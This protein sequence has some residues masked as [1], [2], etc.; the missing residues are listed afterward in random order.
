MVRKLRNQY[1]AGLVECRT[2]NA[3]VLGSFG[4]A[5]WRHFYTELFSLYSKPRGLRE[6]CTALQHTHISILSAIPDIRM[7]SL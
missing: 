2:I 7:M 3:K 5:G 1:V 6:T 4:E